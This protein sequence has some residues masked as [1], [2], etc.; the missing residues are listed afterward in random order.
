MCGMYELFMIHVCTLYFLGL[1]LSGQG[2]YAFQD[3]MAS[4]QGIMVR[5]NT[6]S[7]HSLELTTG[8]LV[9]SDGST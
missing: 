8:E 7:V 6:A 5:V 9:C 1:L 3:T 2:G 4:P